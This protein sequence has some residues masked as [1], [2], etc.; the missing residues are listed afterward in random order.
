MDAIADRAAALPLA[1]LLAAAVLLAGIAA[2][3]LRGLGRLFGSLLWTL[4]ALWLGTLLAPI[5]LGW[6][7]NTAGAGDPRTLVD[8][9]GVLS[10]LVLV[11]PVVARVLGG[12]GT[13]GPREEAVRTHRVFGA[14]AGFAVACLLV[15]LALPFALRVDDLAA[16][17]LDARVPRLAA[18]LAGTLGPLFPE[19][20]RAE[21]DGL[22][23]GPDTNAPAGAPADAR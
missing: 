6:M 14:V 11:L 15:T 9:F 22:A 10:A 16:R 5:L 20:F 23:R 17:S 8:T 19:A 7:P 4:L 18:G 3:L 1:D 2:G 12:S 21:L 13:G